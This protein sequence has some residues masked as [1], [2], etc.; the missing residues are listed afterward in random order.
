[1]GGIILFPL[2]SVRLPI[3]GARAR[4]V[5]FTGGSS[6]SSRSSSNNLTAFR[7]HH[8][9]LNRVWIMLFCCHT[10]NISLA[11]KKSEKVTSSMLRRNFMLCNRAYSC[12]SSR[13]LLCFSTFLFILIPTLRWRSY[14]W[15]LPYLLGILCNFICHLTVKRIEDGK[16]TRILNARAHKHSHTRPCVHSNYIRITYQW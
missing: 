11:K 1:M 16:T 15:L 12:L 14:R 2:R 3:H 6:N 13:T 5:A 10:P 7:C 9:A 4:T 8:F